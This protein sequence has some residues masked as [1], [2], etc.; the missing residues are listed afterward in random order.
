MKIYS[1]NVNGIRAIEK[2]GFFTWMQ[3]ESPDILCLQE[4][5]AQEE[6]L[7][8][9][10]LNQQ[11]Y[12]PYWAAAE[13]KGYSGTAVYTKREP[14]QIERLGAPEF[15]TEGRTQILFYPDFVLVNAYFPNSQPGGARL[16]YKLEFCAALKE[17]TD[18]L[19]REGHNVVI[20]GDYNI[21]HKAIDLARPKENEGNPGY[22]P[23]ERAWM[24]SFI[25][26]GYIDTFR[27]FTPD[28]DNYT[29]WSYRTRAREKNIG[30]RIDYFCV[31]ETFSNSVE[32]SKILSTVMG[33]DHCP[34]SIRI[35]V[36]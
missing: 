13:R 20:C 34:I 5:K 8:E 10:F 23:E 21:A 25:D 2:K 3:N 24:D 14:E 12:T 11:D 32:Q 4:I 1:W 9:I 7:G 22:L 28:P 15:D 27:K 35:G 18:R 33:S 26:G 36:H 30:W 29:W 6:Q 31:N 16:Q 17:R 19:V